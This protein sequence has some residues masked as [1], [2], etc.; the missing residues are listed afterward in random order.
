MPA[1]AVSL[2]CLPA[3]ANE[4]DFDAAAALAVRVIRRCLAGGL[5]AGQVLNVNLPKAVATGEGLPKGLRVVR[6][7]TKGYVDRFERRSTPRGRP[8]YWMTG[9]IAPQDAGADTD[10]AALAAGFVTVTPLA[11][12]L[13]RHAML[14][15]VAGWRWEEVT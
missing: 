5:A 15:A 8:Y 1:V 12:D 2:A 10:V 3:A 4:A 13:T 11:C 14:E 7:C 6:H 9:Q